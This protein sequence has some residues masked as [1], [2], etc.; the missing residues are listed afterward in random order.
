[1]SRTFMGVRDTTKGQQVFIEDEYG[2]K[3]FVYK[4]RLGTGSPSWGKLGNDTYDLSYA[5]L[6][7]I[8]G[9]LLAERTYKKFAFQYLAK[10][11]VNFFRISQAELVTWL[12]EARKDFVGSYSKEM[13]ANKLAKAMNYLPPVRTVDSMPPDY[14]P[15][16]DVIGVTEDHEWFFM[17]CNFCG[18]GF[19][20]KHDMVENP[21]CPCCVKK[22]SRPGPEDFILPI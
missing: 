5:L 21:G 18:H 3:P 16:Y 2:T 15:R 14:K 11:D 1:M 4:P 9:D 17:G 12:V 22:T 10:E 7:T 20:V 19:R 13:V 6:S 8:C